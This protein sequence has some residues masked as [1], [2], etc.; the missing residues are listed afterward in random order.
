MCAPTAPLLPLCQVI[1][2]VELLCGTGGLSLLD[3]GKFA[4]GCGQTVCVAEL[5]PGSEAA[6]L[7]PPPRRLRSVGSAGGAVSASLLAPA[8]GK[9]A[10]QGGR[11]TFRINYGGGGG[12]GVRLVAPSDGK[13]AAEGGRWTVNIG[14]MLGGGSGGAA[15]KGGDEVRAPAPAGGGKLNCGA[16]Q[17]WWDV[18]HHP[19]TSESIER[20]RSCHA[21]DNICSMLGC[22]SGLGCSRVAGCQAAG[23]AWGVLRLRPSCHRSRGDRESLCP[24]EALH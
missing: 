16:C 12:S 11:W 8:D 5:E 20:N 6:A 18:R 23:G 13:G 4:Q 7:A 2:N 21:D 1:D 17:S 14:S 3:M 22:C 19:T 24:L 15:A 9:G 10:A